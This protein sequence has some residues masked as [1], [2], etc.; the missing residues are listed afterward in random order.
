VREDVHLEFKR[1]EIILQKRTNDLANEISAFAN[2]DGGTI[3]IGLSENNSGIADS[4][5]IGVPTEVR[6]T[7]WIEQTIL[8]N[9]R[10][11]MG[12]FESSGSIMVALVCFLVLRPGLSPDFMARLGFRA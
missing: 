1:S 8:S 6:P 9:I 7:E 3:V 12:T 11:H 4:I 5:D 2:S 10:R